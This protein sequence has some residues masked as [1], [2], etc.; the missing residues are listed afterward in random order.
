MEGE[1]QWSVEYGNCVEEVFII[2]GPAKSK[3]EEG[4]NFNL[5]KYC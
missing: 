4:S 3:K 2:S 5:K 1:M